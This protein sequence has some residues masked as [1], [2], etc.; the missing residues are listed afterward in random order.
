MWLNCSL[1]KMNIQFVIDTL[2]LLSGTFLVSL[3]AYV[4]HEKLSLTFCAGTSL[5]LLSSAIL[6]LCKI[7]Y[8]LL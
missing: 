8:E 7:L 4:K 6:T 3:F 2:L 1:D 5:T